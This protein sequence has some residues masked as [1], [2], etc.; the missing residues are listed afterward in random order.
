M[1]MDV[2]TAWQAESDD[3]AVAIIKRPALFAEMLGSWLNDYIGC[4]CFKTDDSTDH[5]SCWHN[6]KTLH[7]VA[8]L[9]KDQCKWITEFNRLMDN[10]DLSLGLIY[11][12]DSESDELSHFCYIVDVIL[13]M[14]SVESK[15]QP[16]VSDT[17]EEPPEPDAREKLMRE[18]IE[19]NPD[20]KMKGKG[21]SLMKRF[22][23]ACEKRKLAGIKEA[24]GL[25]M[26]RSIKGVQKR[27]RHTD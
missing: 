5:C 13:Q 1:E 10:R 21:D 14:V 4:P 23:N 16:P 11:Q 2:E 3:V 17:R 22:R 7:L 26:I 6:L 20:L 25:E 8:L 27:T 19:Q 15:L 18:I 24:A 12:L 9:A